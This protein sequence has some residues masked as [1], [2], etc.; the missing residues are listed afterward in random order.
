MIIDGNFQ[1]DNQL[2]AGLELIIKEAKEKLILVSPYIDLDA[3]IRSALQTKLSE[4]DFTLIVLF[5]KN[6]ENYLRSIK[7]DSLDFL[8]EFPNIE[9]RYEE[10]LHAK[11]YM[12][13]FQY[14]V[15]SMNL[16]N[17]SLANNIE[18]GLVVDYA[19]RGILGKMGDASNKL[20]EAGVDKVKNSVFG[21]K[22][23]VDPI[24]MF[25]SIIANS[26]LLYKTEPVLKD[27]DGLKSFIGMKKLAGKKILVDQLSGITSTQKEPQVSRTPNETNTESRSTV[28]TLSKTQLAKSL[29][30]TNN[31][32][33][34]YYESLGYIQGDN[35]TE[36]GI[37]K[38]I[39]MLKGQ[40][41]PYIGYPENMEEHKKI[42]AK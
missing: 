1:F 32:I 17:Y 5:G 10:R 6:E 33:Q 2:V 12:N 34:E 25:G 15:T 18:F 42:N 39:K 21:V 20:V 3:R 36:I 14:M 19:S 28:K 23:E 13:D 35:I 27:A 7:A 16:Y 29:G 9:I 26:E 22:D 31:R 41:G 30:V 11:F 37:S 4:K 8:K 38:G 24:E 40:Y